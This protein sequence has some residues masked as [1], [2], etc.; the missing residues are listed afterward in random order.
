MNTQPSVPAIE[1][2]WCVLSTVA[3]DAQAIII[4]SADEILIVLDQF[5]QGI[6]QLCGTIL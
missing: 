4:H 6:S 5:H 3:T 1:T 2:H